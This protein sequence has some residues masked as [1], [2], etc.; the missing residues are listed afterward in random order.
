[1]AGYTIIRPPTAFSLSTGRK[2]PRQKDDRHL[3]A[4]RKLPCLICLRRPVEAAHL[5][6]GSLIHG[7]HPTGAGEKP[8]DRWSLPLCPPDHR[9]QHMGNE[10]LFYQA[11]GVEPFGVAALLW[12]ADCDVE[13]MEA[14][15]VNA[16]VRTLEV[17]K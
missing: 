1:M 9:L 5:R 7:K 16:R 13:A 4:I 14:V 2:R 17:V 12:A 10:V 6:T 15:I 11:H 8:D 3:R